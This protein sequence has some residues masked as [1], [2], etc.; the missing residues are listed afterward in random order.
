M[1]FINILNVYRCF[2]LLISA[3]YEK[4]EGHEEQSRYIGIKTL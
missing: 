2:D 1:M 4:T 3:L